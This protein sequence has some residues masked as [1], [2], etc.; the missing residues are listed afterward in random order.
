[1]K[2]VSILFF[3]FIGLLLGQ[4]CHHKN[5]TEE[6]SAPAELTEQT[7]TAFAQEIAD[8]IVHEHADALNNAFDEEYIRQLVSEN[9]IVYSGFDVEGGKEYFENCLHLG[10]QAVKSVS[11]GGDFA[12]VRYYVNDQQHHIVFRTYDD[13]NL[14]FMD[15][16]LDTV[17][18]VLKIKDGFIYNTGS[19]LSKNIEYSMLFNLMLQTNPDDEVQWLH[20][21]Q[22]QTMDGQ[23]AKALQILT[24]HRDGLKEY[25]LYYQLL[26]ANLYQNNPKNFIARLDK[27]KEDVD[28]RYLQ[29]HKLLYYVNEGKVTE[30]ENTINDLIPQTGDDPVFLL[31]YA[32]S[33]L[34]A[35]D[36]Q[37][38]LDCLTTA[39]SALPLLWDLWYSELQCYKGLKDNEGFDQCLQRGKEAYGMSDEELNGIRKKLLG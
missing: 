4:S 25:P 14:N 34:L 19:L 29:L 12:F 18:G 23:S 5:K 33:C 2:R 39:E 24:E 9:S 10:D 20:T 3:C 28:E 35:K 22:E 11:N 13:F 37:R 38:A 16:I 26:I 31:F 8:K 27:L 15:F 7:V 32:K 17:N 21:A 30:T 36:Y 6:T 1:M